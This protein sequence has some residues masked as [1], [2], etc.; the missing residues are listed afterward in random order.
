M[1]TMIAPSAILDIPRPKNLDLGHALITSSFNI[2][3]CKNKESLFEAEMHRSRNYLKMLTELDKND[4]S[5]IVMDEYLVA[6]IQKK[7]FLE[8]MLY[9]T[10]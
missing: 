9:V 4:F 1:P 6:L 2:P 10:N 3:D 8:L 5:F 7:V